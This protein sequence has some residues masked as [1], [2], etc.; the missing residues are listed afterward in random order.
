[1]PGC[2]GTAGLRRFWCVFSLPSSCSCLGTPRAK[3]LLRVLL[4]IVPGERHHSSLMNRSSP[5]AFHM[6][7]PASRACA[8]LRFCGSSQACPTDVGLGPLGSRRDA[9]QELRD[10]AS[11]SRSL[12]TSSPG[13]LN[14]ELRTLNRPQPPAGQT[15][16][17]P[18][19][20][21]ALASRPVSV[22]FRQK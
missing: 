6:E 13:T 9:K 12:G 17:D 2:H 22:S 5:V 3:L 1:Q 10:A 18:V 4:R 21:F 16:L 8:S 7:E 15:A 14:L 19:R 20:R 11:P